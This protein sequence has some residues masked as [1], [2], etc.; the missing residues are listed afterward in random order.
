[1]DEKY[2]Q[3]DGLIKDWPLLMVRKMVKKNIAIG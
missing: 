1:M 2:S 3:R